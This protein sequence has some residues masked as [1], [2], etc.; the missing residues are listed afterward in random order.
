M[1]VNGTN[2]AYIEKDDLYAQKESRT[3]Q[4]AGRIH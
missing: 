3:F 4:T 1:G 2:V